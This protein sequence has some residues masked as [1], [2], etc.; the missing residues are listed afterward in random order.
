MTSLID[1]RK[2]LYSITAGDLGSYAYN[3]SDNLNK[4]FTLCSKWDAIVLLDEADIFLEARS[5][6]EIERNAMVSV[7][8]K[9]LE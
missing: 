7:F 1:V 6:H 3:L 8:L 9:E 2:P 5:N 4:I